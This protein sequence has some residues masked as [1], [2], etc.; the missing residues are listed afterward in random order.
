MALLI[1][2]LAWSKKAEDIVV[3]DVAELTQY[4]DYFV[5]LSAQVD[6]HLKGIADYI[7]E[8][9][10]KQ[11][12]KPHHVEGLGSM[13]WVLIDYIDVIVHLQLPEVRDF[14]DLESLWGEAKN[15]P[16]DFVEEDL[17]N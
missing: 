1:S 13:R 2:R 9:L 11:T 8:E 14:Y 16:L 4:T 6:L 5:I 3:L 12:I 17:E 7:I 10:K 15:V